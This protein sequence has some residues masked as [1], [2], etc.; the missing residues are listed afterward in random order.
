[1]IIIYNKIL[2]FKGFSAVLT[3]FIL[4]IR[5]EHKGSNKLDEQFFNHERIHVYQQI[6]IWIVS[7]SIVLVVCLFL[8]LSWWWMIITPLIPLLIYVIC[9]IIELILPPYDRAYGNICF[10]SEAIYNEANPYYFKDRKLFTFRWIKYI[11][12]KKYPYVPKHLR[13]NLVKR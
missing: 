2:P 13:K 4:W 3:I 5:K 11:P 6:E 12:N 10:E 1:M 8:S 9:W 7:I